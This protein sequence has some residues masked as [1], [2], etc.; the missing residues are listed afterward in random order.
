MTKNCVYL[1]PS[2]KPCGAPPLKDGQFCFWHE[3]DKAE[4]VADARRLGGLRRKREKTV[5]LA[6][7]VDGLRDVDQVRRVLEIALVDTLS[8]DNSV[9]RNRTLISLAQTGLKAMETGEL[10]E[11]VAQLEAA[12]K[13]HALPPSAFDVELG[14]QSGP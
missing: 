7:D 9:P 13:T 6:Y 11:R 4:D 12:V 14:E 1:K 5:A 8:L 10:E 3:P 2:G